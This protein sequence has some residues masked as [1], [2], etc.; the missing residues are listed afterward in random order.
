MLMQRLLGPGTYERLPSDPDRVPPPEKRSQ[1][2]LWATIVV[3]FVLLILW[4]VVKHPPPPYSPLDNYQNMHV[5]VFSPRF[6][7]FSLLTNGWRRNPLPVTVDPGTQKVPLNR[8]AIVSA[9]DSDGYAI[10]VA[11][12][13]YS[14]RDANVTARLLLPYLENKVSERALCIARAVGWEPYPVPLIPP[15]RG[16]AKYVFPRFKEQYTKLHIWALD[17]KDVDSAVYIDAD[18]LVL[19]NFDELFESPFNFAA[20][21]DVYCDRRGFSI[22]FNAGVLAFRPSSAVY[23]DMRRKMEIAQYPPGEA[24][25]GFLNLYFAATAMHLPY[26]YNANLAIKDR[27]LTLW[28]RLVPEMRIVHYTLVKPFLPDPDHSHEILT[29]DQITDAVVQ[30]ARSRE[31]LFSGG[32]RMVGSG[33]S[34]DDERIRTCHRAMSLTSP[35]NCHCHDGA[36]FFSDGKKM[37]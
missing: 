11:V 2:R 3:V 31:G 34:Q 4:L 30:A 36:C 16:G 33:V 1:W 21:P 17:K 24:E 6:S 9:L 13:G 29:G 35:R 26:I 18:T 8:R 23:E 37:M 5:Q 7:L 12:A 19:R 27:S 20:T 14:A 28:E 15:P 22:M 25:Q 32:G 10:A